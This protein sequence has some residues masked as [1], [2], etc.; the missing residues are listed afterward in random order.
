MW[1]MVGWQADGKSQ[2]T[3]FPFRNTQ[4]GLLERALGGPV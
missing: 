1:D 3:V 4:K 2:E